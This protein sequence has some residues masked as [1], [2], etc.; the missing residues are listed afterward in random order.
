MPPFQSPKLMP[1]AHGIAVASLSI[2]IAGTIVGS[3]HPTLNRP[4]A[5]LPLAKTTTAELVNQQSKLGES[6]DA[7]RLVLSPA[8]SSSEA[9]V[10]NYYFFQSFYQWLRQFWPPVPV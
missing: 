5:L 6:V 4:S 1:I 7:S 8:N 3:L 9:Q 2:G 10:A